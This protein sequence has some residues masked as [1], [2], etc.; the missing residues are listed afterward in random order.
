MFPWASFLSALSTKD[1][2]LSVPLPGTLS[3]IPRRSGEYLTPLIMGRLARLGEV[4]SPRGCQG[5]SMNSLKVEITRAGKSM[6]IHQLKSWHPTPSARVFASLLFE[7]KS[8]AFV[9]VTREW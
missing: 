2:L 1:Q 4:S 3:E 7:M 9:A 6:E 8:S 5:N